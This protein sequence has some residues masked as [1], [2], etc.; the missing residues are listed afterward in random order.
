MKLDE[1]WPNHLM[2]ID[3]YKLSQEAPQGK[4]WDSRSGT[5]GAKQHCYSAKQQEEAKCL[6]RQNNNLKHDE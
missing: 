4:R 6:S 1:A 5:P 2:W 3:E